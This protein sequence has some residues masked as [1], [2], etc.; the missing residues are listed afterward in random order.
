MSRA[1][2]EDS[3][4]SDPHA[5]GREK[6]RGYESEACQRACRGAR[7]RTGQ[8]QNPRPSVLPKARRPRVRMGNVL[9]GPHQLNS[10]NDL[11]AGWGAGCA[12]NSPR[13][14]RRPAGTPRSGPRDRRLP[15]RSC[16]RAAR[17]PGARS[18]GRDRSHRWP[19]S[20]ESSTRANRSKIR[21]RSP[22]GTP[23]PSS[24][25]VRTASRVPASS[26]TSRVT[27]IRD[28]ANLVAFSSRLRT[29]LASSSALPRTSTGVTADASIRR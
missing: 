24:A 16:P 19:D 28:R 12:R 9:P 27:P 22:G 14:M 4:A 10:P 21:S 8:P 25:T 29:S 23:G 11:E 1:R 2:L 7:N 6:H 20:C 3:A 17:P 18:R 15:A 13:L 5:A 26:R